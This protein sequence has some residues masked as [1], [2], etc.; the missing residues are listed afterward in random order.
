MRYPISILIS[1]FSYLIFL[2]SCSPYLYQT[3]PTGFANQRPLSRSG[4]QVDACNFHVNS[5]G[6]GLRWENLPVEITLHHKM[7][8]QAVSAVLRTVEGINNQWLSYSNRVYPNLIEVVGTLE[9]ESFE[10]LRSDNHNTITFINALTDGKEGSEAD[11]TYLSNV[12]QINTKIQGITQVQGRRT[13]KAADVYINDRDYQFY[14]E[15]NYLSQ[16]SEDK[17]TRNLASHNTEEPSI[18]K[19]VKNFFYQIWTLIS[20]QKHLGREVASSR[21]RYGSRIPRNQLDF[22]SLTTHELLHVVGVGHNNSRYSVMNTKLSK[23]VL[24]R[25]LKPDDLKSLNCGYQNL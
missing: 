4:E 13:F 16:N 23:G 15:D 7:S 24:R 21:S 12:L 11:A 22:E 6:F 10:P 2:T 19:M 3:A 18:F 9:Y 20:F 1:I 25:G 8:D 14:Y 5:Y 17:A